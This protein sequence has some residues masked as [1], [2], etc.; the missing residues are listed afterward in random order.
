M[1]HKFKNFPKE[2]ENVF[3]TDDVKNKYKEELMSTLYEDG[4]DEY[5][6]FFKNYISEWSN[7]MFTQIVKY[8]WLQKHFQF[9]GVQKKKYALNKWDTDAAYAFF[10]RHILKFSHNTIL[11]SFWTYKLTTYLDEWFPDMMEH[12]PFTEPEF[13]KWPY[14]N[15][16]LDFVIAVYQLPERK[17]LLEYVDTQNMSAYEY[18]DYLINYV[19]VFNERHKG[20]PIY[21]FIYNMTTSPPYIRFNRSKTNIKRIRHYKEQDKY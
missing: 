2:Y 5:K 19:N 18:Y 15:I 17:E 11:K 9:K 20:T 3:L 7:E 13:F 4:W 6:K 8:Y 1:K 10:I 12:N 21:R 14:K 16:T